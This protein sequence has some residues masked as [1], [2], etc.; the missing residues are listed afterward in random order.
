MAA[1]AQEQDTQKGKQRRWLGQHPL[2]TVLRIAATLGSVW[3][4]GTALTT[5][6]PKADR[7]APTLPSAD[8]PSSL[9]PFP[10]KPV[11]VMVLSLIHI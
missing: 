9:A 1:P 11:T 8:D 2:R 5:L 6:W 10:S 7:V 4:V 3:V